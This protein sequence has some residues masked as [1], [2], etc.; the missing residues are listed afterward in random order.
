MKRAQN[1]CIFDVEAPGE[2]NRSR[3][4]AWTASRF[5]EF[6]LHVLGLL[7]LQR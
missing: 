3:G 6:M 4:R 7:G 1:Q 5:A 2:L